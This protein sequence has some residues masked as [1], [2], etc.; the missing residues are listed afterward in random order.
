MCTS[1]ESPATA[2]HGTSP[3]DSRP[4]SA[5]YSHSP[6]PSV[7]D[8]LERPALVQHIA[9]HRI[10]A[11]HALVCPQS[12]ALAP[13]VQHVVHH[14]PQL[15]RNRHRC[16]SACSDLLRLASY[17]SRHLDDLTWQFHANQ[18]LQRLSEAGHHVVAIHTQVVVTIVFHSEHQHVAQHVMASV[19]LLC[20]NPPLS[21]H[22]SSVRVD[23]SLDRD[24][25]GLARLHHAVRL[26]QVE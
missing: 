7:L 4:S 12:S 2:A 14:A 20:L 16:R 6:L 5:H 13:I 18:I 8:S 23:Q 1:R 15:L 9:D 25:E 10:L 21:S 3:A 26:R 19:Q 24:V 11:L 17:L 22:V